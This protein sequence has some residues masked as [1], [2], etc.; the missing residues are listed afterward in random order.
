MTAQQ[1]P[2][3]GAGEDDPDDR[4]ETPREPAEVAAQD[5][6]APP[7]HP[8]L[9]PTGEA[10]AWSALGSLLAGPA[11]WGGL[12]AL[13]DH[14]LGTGRIFLVIGLVVGAVTGMWIVYLRFG[15]DDTGT[16]RS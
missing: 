11:V 4:L 3:S 2:G 14:M 6:A 10:V 5:G 13:A 15:Q 9:E 12:G 7:M 1:P 16:P 8:S